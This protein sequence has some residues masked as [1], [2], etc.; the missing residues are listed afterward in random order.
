[1]TRD[2]DLLQTEDLRK[3][4]GRKA[5]RGAL[6]LAVSRPIKAVLLFGFTALLARL[7]TP[8]DFGLVG[9]VA[10]V[11]R[12][13]DIFSDVGLGTATIQRENLTNKQLNAVF[14]INAGIS[15]SF[16]VLVVALSPAVAWFYAE[17]RL[18]Q[19]TMVLAA[20]VFISG[21]SIQHRSLLRRR[22][23]FGAISIVE[24]IAF[25][26]ANL[27]AVGLAI[28][29]AAY[30]ALVTRTVVEALAIGIGLWI[31]SG[32]RPG[33]PRMAEGVR[34]LVTFGANLTGFNL[35]NFFSR[36]ADDLLIGR[37]FG[38]ATLGVYQKAYDL[39]MISLKQIN[40]PVGTV[41]VSAL[42]RL[43]G[44][45]ELYR[46]AYLRMVDKVM[47][48]TT[49]GAVLMLAV[50]DW[51]VRVLLGRQWLEAV[52]LV[53]IFGVTAMLQ[54]LSNTVGW[55][56]TTQGRTPGLLRLG[57]LTAIFNLA[58]FALG[59]A[60]GVLGITIAYSAG[61]VV[62]TPLALALVA[63]QG[64]V[65]QRDM[66]VTLFTFVSAGAVA[67]LA[68]LGIRKVLPEPGP[69]LGLIVAGILACAA[70]W[71]T[72]LLTRRGREAVADVPPT[73]RL[74]LSKKK[75]DA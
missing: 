47:L 23:R 72:L 18:T 46:R 43:T 9:M 56:F 59:A 67:T 7:L 62:R 39:M 8:T 52:P 40:R 2:E 48:L 27:A 64:A 54:P 12:F 37:F 63:Q 69:L 44:E 13:I 5:A 26:L 58:L 66:Y 19:I 24:L 53:A 42:S 61:Q 20:G 49:P 31:A 29:G 11:S 45:P 70:T 25:A 41:A 36:N 6:V 65:R 51:F 57:V 35:I 38:A 17:P 3:G 74:L 71:G 15:L 33:W 28:W 55:L 32:W 30:W 73:V 14:W 34:E 68:L 50:P 16:A 1:M 22:M 21:V 60:W 10:V 4:V 75:A